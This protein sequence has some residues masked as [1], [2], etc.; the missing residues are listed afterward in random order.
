MTAAKQ[1][2]SRFA[3][4]FL[5]GS[6]LALTGCTK[7]HSEAPQLRPVRAVEVGTVRL[8]GGVRYSANIAPYSQVDLAFKS[9]G[10]LAQLRQV[11]GADGRVRNV[12]EGDWVAK[13]T[14]LAE[15]RRDDY[16]HQLAQA[17]AQLSRAQASQ[18]QAKLAYDRTSILYSTQAAT[19]PEY[20]SAKAQNDSAAAGVKEA[21][22]AV[23]Q[24]ETALND[25][26]LRAPFDAWI[27]K[28]NV[29]IGSLVGSATVGF[30]LADTRFVKAVF[31]VPDTAIGRVKLGDRQTIATDAVARKFA[32]RVTAISPAADPRSRVYSVEVTIP[33]PQNQLRAGMI[34]SLALGETEPA[35]PA[36][37]VPLDAVVRDPGQPNAFAVLVAEGAGDT[38]TARLR[39][40]E[41]GDAH[42]NMITVLKG[43]TAGER[44]LTSGAA[45]VKSGEQVHII[46]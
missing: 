30:S 6:L 13:G 44:V 19:K 26:S 21:E 17:K 2:F 29:D 45:Y 24:A 4:A 1:I 36:L 34:A 3:L 42:G 33:N 37:A 23:A 27:L 22:A 35:H 25:C 11:R 16:E 46:P 7:G 28:R 39:T 20:D 40:V 5:A 8:D 32:G 10:Y 18:E 43:V 15:V 14:V 41:L 12:G 38:A 9:G 31:G